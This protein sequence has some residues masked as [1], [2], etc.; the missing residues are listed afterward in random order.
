MT[1]EYRVSTIVVYRPPEHENGKIVDDRVKLS[2]NLSCK[3]G[4]TTKESSWRRTKF[5]FTHVG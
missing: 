1:V 2:Y 3:M 5:Q 4:M